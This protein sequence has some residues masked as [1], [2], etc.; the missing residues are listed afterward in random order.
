[1]GWSPGPPSY[2]Y[3]RRPYAP[4]SMARHLAYRRP[5]AIRSL[6][7]PTLAAT[8]PHA[9]QWRTLPE[10]QHEV[11]EDQRQ[12]ESRAGKMPGPRLHQIAAE[13]EV[14]DKP[15]QHHNMHRQT[16]AER[17]QRTAQREHD[18]V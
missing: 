8:P 7:G 10:H 16:H 14:D 9:R 2:S 12:L 13:P 11:A 1:M 5:L 3:T 15:D 17:V 6:I 18:H 4:D